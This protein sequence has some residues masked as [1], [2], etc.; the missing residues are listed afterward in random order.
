MLY[1]KMYKVCILVVVFQKF[2]PSNLRKILA[3]VKQLKQ[4]L[5]PEYLQSLSVG[6]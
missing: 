5:L 1:L 2:L 3:L 6:D 4:L